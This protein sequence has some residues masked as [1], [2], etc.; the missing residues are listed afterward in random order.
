MKMLSFTTNKNSKI[1]ILIICFFCLL[2]IF[3]PGN[4]IAQ[5]AAKRPSI[6]LVLS[7]GGA[8]GIAH[9]GVLKVMEEAGLRPDYITGVSMG[10]II[11]GMYALGYSADSLQKIFK[12]INW[13]IILSNKI[14]E[15]KVIFLEKNHFS[16]SAVS[17]PL[18][19][20]KVVLP[21]G[22]INGQQVENTLSFYT[23]PAADI[24]D[25]SKLP[26]PFLCVATDIISYSKVILTK[27][28]LTDAIRASFSVPSIFT[29]I[30]IDSLLLLDGGL[31]R[32][33]AATEV[34]EMG[35]DIII[36]SYVG[37]N[38]YKADKL[39]TVS[40][41]MEQIAMFRSLD[42]FEKEKKFVDVLVKPETTG[43]SIFGFDN[44]DSLIHRGYVAALPFRE[45][46]KK[47]ADSLNAIGVQEP[48]KNILVKKDYT[49][50]KIDITGNKYYSKDQI[51]GVL[52]LVPGQKVSSSMITERIELLYGKAWF[53]K[54]KY[55]IIPRNDSLILVID[56]IEK[57]QSMLYGA[58]HY[59]NSLQSG[60]IFEISL[61]NPLTQ[62]SMVNFR[63]R[64]GQY[65]RFDLSYLQF[66]DK[67]QT[68]G[69]S[70][71]LFSDNTLIPMLELRGDRGDVISRNFT[72]EFSINRRIGLNNMMSI[73]ESFENTNLKVRYL[74][75]VSLKNLSFNYVTTACNYQIN[76]LDN[77]HFPD[78]GTKFN[79]SAGTSKLQS[80]SIRTDS[81]R[82]VLRWSKYS[83]FSSDRFY[84]FHATIDHF[85]SP[86]NRTT[87]SFGGDILITTGSDSISEQNNFHLLGGFESVNKRSIPMIGFQTNEIAVNKLAG[88]RT[89]FDIEP[90]ESFHLNIMANLF[91]V[92][93]AFRSKGY[94]L[95]S[96]VGIGAGYMSIIGPLKIGLMYGNYRRELFFHKIKGYISIGY[97]F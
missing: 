64:I 73:S 85:Y 33:F 25:F 48:L 66:I 27:G 62:R 67:N 3:S 81:S 97:N 6:G 53:D 15:N 93:E 11:G 32:N 71:T 82:S 26:I 34:M 20:R 83:L 29:P 84:T 79:F 75:D 76:S 10:S 49:F 70:A 60:L 28:Y 90:V 87:F 88:F 91:V 59:D 61:K 94:S 8:H 36:G 57:P 21:S 19:L 4:I 69:L 37:F 77:K 16:N 31:I 41:I 72:S 22:L 18:A 50:N 96:G 58:V 89:S 30:K 47:L 44:S 54:V 14:P 39:Q 38:G 43:L 13:K 78:K 17:L 7:G 5:K 95:L 51:R 45:Y 40:G 46:F 9:I 63:S 74:S 55:R 92:Q 12:S 86:T 80:A 23:W 42:D 65:F 1:T 52:D 2:F 56:C 24:S 68:Y 35:A